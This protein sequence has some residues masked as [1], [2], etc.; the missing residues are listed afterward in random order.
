MTLTARQSQIL[1][2]VHRT[3][4]ARVADL[5]VR[6]GVS[7]MTVRRDIAVLTGYRLV[8]RVY[9]G[10]T[11]PGTVPLARSATR[12]KRQQRN[13]R[14]SLGMV[15]P[16]LTLY[17][18]YVK[19]G[20][21]AV[22]EECGA[23]LSVVV[24]DHDD[25]RVQVERLLDGGVHGFLLTPPPSLLDS[26]DASLWLRELPVPAV[27]MERRPTPMAGLDHLD[28]V[29]SDHER[30]VLQALRHLAE[31]GHRR[32][33]L[34]ACS[35][36]TTPWIV[37]GFDTAAAL[38]GLPRDVPRVTDARYEVEEE[39]DAFLDSARS[40]GVSAAIAHPDGQASLL[41]QRALHRGLSVPDDLAIVT[42]DDD[43]GYLL[44]IPLTGVAPPRR[45]IGRIAATRLVGRL[46]EDGE[47]VP[48]EL[49]LLPRLNIRA[50]TS[51][52]QMSG[53]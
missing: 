32:I 6:F 22:A 23:R 31:I 3:G 14:L 4:S 47:H 27:I 29:A 1:E 51:G 30:G 37:K 7:A 9:G 44:A 17:Y 40:A 21:Q 2:E 8:S 25:V 18:W 5:A 41:L 42:Y 34:L 36:P 19:Q 35:T 52:P 53:L 24:A 28:R 43:W 38:F 46:R 26:A 16:Y 49:L 13:Q 12:A 10:V 50:S 33:G 11:L 39:I 20:A 15:V 45:A 48:Q